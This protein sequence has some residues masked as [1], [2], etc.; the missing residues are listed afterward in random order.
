MI[1]DI[2]FNTGPTISGTT[3]VNDIAISNDNPDYTSGTWVGG[4]DDSDGYV[5]VSDTTSAGLVGRPADGGT[6]TTQSD[7][8]TFWKST[9]LSDDSLVTL[10]N[11]LPGSD[12]NYI[13]V[14]EARN[15]ISNSYTYSILN[16][17]SAVGGSFAFTL[18]TLPYNPPTAGNIIFP[19]LGG[20]GSEGILNPNTF[21][22]NSAYWSIQDSLSVDVSADFNA[23]IGSQVEM[24][25]T[26]GSN[27][28]T[29]LTSAI[30][31]GPGG[32][33]VPA[34]FFIPQNDPT[35]SLITPSMNDFIAG[36]LVTISWTVV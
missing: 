13:N 11:K 17:L 6:S 9:Y 36:E 30:T 19:V 33:A 10:I 34:S 2:A 24:T 22:D 7:L 18:V 21:V 35:T 26:Q 8:P 27:S 4:V 20:P 25:F 31:F 5:I 14:T 16:D 15:F 32:G 29:Y 3:Q 1:R 23:L 12:G 28:A